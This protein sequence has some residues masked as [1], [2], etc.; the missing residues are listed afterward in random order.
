[1]PVRSPSH[2][3]GGLSDDDDDDDAIFLLGD[4]DDD[5]DDLAHL[6]G[7]DDEVGYPANSSRRR[8][9]RG[10]PFAWAGAALVE[11]GGWLFLATVGVTTALVTFAID[12]VI[13]KLH[14]AR[15]LAAD[16]VAAGGDY[17]VWMIM[18][19]LL[20]VIAVVWTRLIS[21]Q[22]IGSGIPEMKT[23]L[24][25]TGAIDGTY[26]SFRTLL[27][28]TVGLI[29]ARGSGL[30]IGKEGPSVHIASAIANLLSRLSWF[31]HVIVTDHHRVEMLQA[32]AAVGVSCN[33]GAPIGGALFSIEVTT[34][35]FFAIRNYWRGLFAALAGALTFRVLA[36][37]LDDKKLTA[38]FS[39]DFD[40]YPYD[41]PEILAFVLLGIICGLLGAL[42]VRVHLAFVTWSRRIVARYPEGNGLLVKADLVRVLI[43]VFIFASLTFPSGLGKFM[44]LSQK[45]AVETFFSSKPLTCLGDTDPSGPWTAFNIF[46]ELIIFFFVFGA[47]TIASISLPL[48][49][50]VFMPV[51][52]V[53]ACLGRLAGEGMNVLFPDGIA[54][55]NDGSVT[56]Q[57][58]WD[59]G[60]RVLSYWWPV[61][62]D[63]QAFLAQQSCTFNITSGLCEPASTPSAF[64]CHNMRNIVPGGYALVGAAALAGAVTHTISTSI[65]VFELTGQMIHIIPV[66]LAVL[67][68]NGIA[69]RLSASIYDSII[70]LNGLPYL[71]DLQQVDSYKKTAGQIMQ[72]RIFSIALD[73]TYS[74]LAQVMHR[75][76]AKRFPVIDS[77]QSNIFLGTVTRRELRYSLIKHMRI[78]R[79]KEAAKQ[80]VQVDVEAAA[81]ATA[82][83]GAS[84]RDAVVAPLGGGR[85]GAA[86]SAAAA[87]AAGVVAATSPANKTTFDD[88]AVPMVPVV[89]GHDSPS[90]SSASSRSHLH[91]I[92]FSEL[93]L[94]QTAA[95]VVEQTDLSTVH[96]MFSLLGN[97][98]LYVTQ[99]G[100]LVGV[101]SIADLRH[102]VLYS[103][104][105]T[106]GN[107]TNGDGFA[108]SHS[109]APGVEPTPTVTPAETPAPTPPTSPSPPCSPSRDGPGE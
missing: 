101:I 106:A 68:S 67:V 3:Y 53:G 2:H 56:H 50:G 69:Q 97:K 55:G 65:I 88:D 51:F 96:A 95:R 19:A 89:D 42:F 16:S 75:C 105:D 30:P 94:D 82:G 37:A 28:K 57:V 14:E 73:C 80:L 26:L 24:R 86:A 64:D 99:V 48:P 70:Q 90:S 43:A 8:R 46:G 12:Y 107:G 74:K 79:A 11:G 92:D 108:G 84:G 62:N 15:G 5:D 83:S 21:A 102:A 25:D 4:G 23:I 91:C 7:L 9:N 77:E 29:F 100:R 33:F 47:M 85:P 98:Y 40:Q 38:L 27:S 109:L 66:L 13:D 34:T 41:L 103:R 52:V 35:S 39:T 31:K 63:G 59:T 78:K 22:G 44:G 61:A 87:A 60:S 36:A 81:A 20:A 71:P 76:K 17:F 104:V 49:A 10:S 6:D 1:M 18:M 54:D 93:N 45:Q 58:H 72:R 32:A